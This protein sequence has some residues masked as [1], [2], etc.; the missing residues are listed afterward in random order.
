M[1]NKEKTGNKH[2]NLQEKRKKNCVIVAISCDHNLD[3]NKPLK[4]IKRKA[5]IVRCMHTQRSAV[6]Y[7]AG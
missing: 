1:M 4:D 2:E 3:A 6:N 5:T 7:L